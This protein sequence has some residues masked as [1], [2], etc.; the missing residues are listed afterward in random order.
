MAEVL[1]WV[2]GLLGMSVIVGAL[3]RYG[4]TRGWRVRAG[5]WCQDL[6]AGYRELHELQGLLRRPWEEELLHWSWDGQSWRLH[7]HLD[8]PRGRRRSTTSSGWCPA[9]RNRSTDGDRPEP[10]R[11]GSGWRRPGTPAG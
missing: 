11:A 6:W 3:A 1:I 4:R 5:H 10:G 9:V 7:G 2:I 8:P